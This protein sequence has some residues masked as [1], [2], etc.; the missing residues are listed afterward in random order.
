V[1]DAGDVT[2]ADQTDRRAGFAHRADQ[3]GMA[4]PIEDHSRD[5]LGFDT[6]GLG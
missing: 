5:R 1:D 3:I 2:V 4:R 6:F